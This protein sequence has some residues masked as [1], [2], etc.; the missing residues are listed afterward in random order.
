MQKREAIIRRRM[1]EDRRRR[2]EKVTE[3]KL[4][5]I[6]EELGVQID[7]LRKEFDLTEG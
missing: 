5:A 3:A 2:I 6:R 1:E 4:Q 7:D